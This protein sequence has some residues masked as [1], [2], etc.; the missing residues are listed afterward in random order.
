MKPILSKEQADAFLKFL[1]NSNFDGDLNVKSNLGLALLEEI[2]RNTNVAEELHAKFKDVALSGNIKMIQGMAGKTPTEQEV[3]S[4]IRPFIPKSKPGKDGV[5]PSKAELKALIKSLIPK[6]QVQPIDIKKDTPREIKRKLKKVGINIDDVKGLKEVLSVNVDEKVTT[7]ERLKEIEDYLDKLKKVVIYNTSGAAS[8]GTSGGV[9]Y[10]GTWDADTNTPTL[11]DGTGTQ[12]DYYVVSVAGSTDLDGITDWKVGDWAIFNGT[13]WQKVDNTESVTSVFGRIGAVVAAAGDYSADQIDI[14]VL[15]SP[16]YDNLEDTMNTGLGAGCISGGLI[17][18]AG[19][20]EIDISAVTGYLRTTDS[21]VG[22]LVSFDLGAAS[23]LAIPANEIRYIAVEYNA[24]TP[25][26]VV[27]ATNDF[28]GRDEFPI[29]VVTN[30]GGTLHIM[31]NPQRASDVQARLLHR[32]YERESLGRADYL[33]DIILGETGT[34]YLT[35]SAG[36]LY[37]QINEFDISAID[38]TPVGD[39][40]DSYSA[41]GQESA[42][43]TQWDNDNYDNAGTLTTLA[44]NRYA[45]LWLYMETDGML[46]CVYGT[47]EYTVLATAELES[48]PTTLPKR[49]QAAQAILIGRLTFQKGGA[50]AEAIQTA[51][52]DG[53]SATAATNHNNLAG[54]QG[55]AAGE[56]NHLTD[57][58]VTKLAG[59][60]AGAEVNVGEEFTSADETKLDGIET[61]ADVTDAVNV[62]SANA[63]ASAKTTPVD[64][65]TMPLNDSAAANVLKKLTWANVKATLKTYF[66]TLY[67]PIGGGGGSDIA[68]TDVLWN[69]IYEETA[70]W[71]K[72]NAGTGSFLNIGAT[73]D[74]GAGLGG[75]STATGRAQA[76]IRPFG[77]TI[78]NIGS[79]AAGKRAKKTVFNWAF[80]VIGVGTSN[81][82]A[83]LGIGEDNEPINS[84]GVFAWAAIDHFGFLLEAIDATTMTVKGSNADA[85]AQNL[86]ASLGT[87]T[88]GDMVSLTMVINDDDDS[89]DYYISINDAD[90]S[91][92]VNVTDDFNTDRAM[93]WNVMGVGNG[94]GT[95][96]MQ[97][98][99]FSH[100]IRKINS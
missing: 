82:E 84:S 13:V 75:G 27:S 14:N 33:G 17:T 57:A 38:T 22:S 98:D 96:N 60:E 94:A 44:A 5:T 66:D 49:L 41:S 54:L 64:A 71:S 99:M 36:E 59:I 20:A 67:A 73:D 69:T 76:Y 74:E 97:L 26:F 1:D 70:R 39:T 16:T 28:N 93:R 18:D 92:P 55:G 52:G 85:S 46:V 91:S 8:N 48:A 63:G 11:V 30:E 90:I 56:Y 78:G 35:V 43:D 86:T 15:G 24:G 45:N 42:A 23:G 19:G 87:L 72:S 25:Q 95:G 2:I 37:N 88:V 68:L 53:F 83:F 50:T 77:A 4:I 89:V 21:S 51:W 6:M 79:A 29:G 10:K 47:A 81:S 65:D 62:G 80:T 32:L 31:N 12:G 61:A 3:L 7:E 40:F 58:N 34:R 9:T 100:T